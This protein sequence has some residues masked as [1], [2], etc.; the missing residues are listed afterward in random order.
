[1]VPSMMKSLS[2]APPPLQRTR[3]SAP[4]AGGPPPSPMASPPPGEKKK[5]A[6]ISRKPARPTSGF[7]EE[8]EGAAPKGDAGSPL[9]ARLVLSKGLRLV[10]ELEVKVDLDWEP[11]DEVTVTLDDGSRFAARV[12]RIATTSDGAYGPGAVVRLAL[13]L[14]AP[15]P[16]GAAPSEVT[17]AGGRLTIAVRPAP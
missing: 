3:A 16:P 9:V 4:A 1:V 7:E 17:A 14:D 2:D 12:D 15:L 11:G 5:E 8:A 10:F 6:R 13:D